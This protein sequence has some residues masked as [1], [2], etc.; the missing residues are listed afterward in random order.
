CVYLSCGTGRPS[1]PYATSS[2]G[3]SSGAT[4]DSYSRTRHADCRAL[5][6]AA[7]AAAAGPATGSA[8]NL[9]G[10]PAAK[11]AAAQ[12]A[13]VERI[14]GQN[15]EFHI[16]FNRAL[17]DPEKGPRLKAAVTRY[18]ECSLGVENSHF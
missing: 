17:S 9:P 1:C 13:E 11:S 10:R 7:P 2:A 14:C 8:I 18:Q 15:P 6:P 12:N 4:L 16:L 3:T 5:P